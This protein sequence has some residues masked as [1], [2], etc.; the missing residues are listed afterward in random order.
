MSSVKSRASEFTHLQL[1]LD[2]PQLREFSSL[3]L[4]D[5]PGF[6]SSLTNHNKAIAYY[7]PR[8]AHFIVV[9]SVEDGNIT[10]SMMRQIDDLQTYEC[11]FTFVLNKINLRSDEQVDDVAAIIE[12]QIRFSFCNNQPLVRIGHDGYEKAFWNTSSTGS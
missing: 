9:T 11:G 7:L 2:N 5:M 4:V 12:E 8:G 3:V 6:G 10:Q 1:F